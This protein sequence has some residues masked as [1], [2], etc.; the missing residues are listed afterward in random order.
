MLK[1]NKEYSEKEYKESDM[2]RSLFKAAL[3]VSAILALVAML[4]PS[5]AFAT[6]VPFSTGT[7]TSNFNGANSVYAAVVD[8]DKCFFDFKKRRCNEIS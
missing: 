1:R 6:N 3:A 4:D 2:G 8:D 5:T 7:I